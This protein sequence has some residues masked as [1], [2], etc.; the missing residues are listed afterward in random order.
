M[1]FGIATMMLLAGAAADGASE[2]WKRRMQGIQSSQAGV[3]DKDFW[4]NKDKFASGVGR[5]LASNMFYI[6]DIILGLQNQIQGNRGFDPASRVFLVSLIQAMSNAVTGAYQTA[7]G[8]GKGSDFAVPLIDAASRLTPGAQE[9]RKLFGANTDLRRSSQITAA[10]A[11]ALNMEMPRPGAAPSFG[12]T[13]VV[14]RLLQ[15]SVGNMARAQAEGDAVGYDKAVASAQEQITK[16][17]DF[18]VEQRT[19]LGDTP[20]EAAKHAKQAVWRDYQETNPVLAAL[21]GRRVTN[22]EYQSLTSG[23]TGE[24]AETQQR[25]IEAWQAG[26]QALFGRPGAIT[27][28]EVAATRGGSGVSP[29]AATAVGG[30]SGSVGM[31]SAGRGAGPGGS[32]G[33]R[34]GRLTLRGRAP[35]RARVSMAGVSRLQRPRATTFKRLSLTQKLA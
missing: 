18:Y 19:K 1:L 7:Q 11:R 12:P 6:G 20:E 17:T 23:A 32:R 10:E 21:G 16:L 25:G 5:F 31:I 9:L 29:V 30:G 8:A 4:D 35:Q 15:E 24:R 22:A 28:E 27:K 34:V 13:T 3:L 14:R 33:V 2:Y 26:A